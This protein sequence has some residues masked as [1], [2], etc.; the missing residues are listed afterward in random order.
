MKNLLSPTKIKEG[1]N[2]KTQKNIMIFIFILII[3]SAFYPKLTSVAFILL[4][5]MLIMAAW[6]WKEKYKK[7]FY[8]D[9]SLSILI[10]ILS[11]LKLANI[12]HK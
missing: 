7:S 1:Y 11:V 4:G 2:R 12:T 9:L 10:I 6:K 8:F 5:I 3:P